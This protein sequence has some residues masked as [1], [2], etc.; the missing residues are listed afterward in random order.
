MGPSPRRPSRTSS[1]GHLV[2]VA[3]HGEA[4][5]VLLQFLLLLLV[6]S[7]L[8]RGIFVSFCPGWLEG[9]WSCMAFWSQDARRGRS[10][11]F[12]ICLFAS[13]CRPPAGWLRRPAAI[14]ECLTL[15]RR[16]CRRCAHTP[17]W[18]G[19]SGC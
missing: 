7:S 18:A 5:R 9:A 8:H 14:L 19:S 1:E 10:H 6:H 12:H 13:G 2:C 15:A 17:P 11:V 4:L 16:R 3:P